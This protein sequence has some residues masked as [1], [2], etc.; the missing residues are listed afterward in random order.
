MEH[1]ESACYILPCNRLFNLLAI[2]T[3]DILVT[4]LCVALILWA[5]GDA[6]L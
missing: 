1:E 5:P 4:I 3:F 2:R 6:P